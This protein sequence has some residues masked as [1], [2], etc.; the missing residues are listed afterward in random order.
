MVSVAGD[1]VANVV[2]STASVTGTPPAGAGA[3]IC[4][5]T[6]VERSA[7]TGTG[8][9]LIVSVSA[10]VTL[11]VSAA[12]PA[13]VAVMTVVPA[14]TPVTC[15]FAT[16]TCCP[17]G[18]TTV[19]VTVA[20]AGLLLVKCMTRLPTAGVVMLTGRLNDCSGASTG[21]LPMLMRLLVT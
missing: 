10:T 11:R 2:L 19:G 4:T 20:T 14:L 16:G 17:L 9:G 18:I 21:A 3:E 6:S 5:A 13:A 8:E 1:T 12:K 7:S 15:G